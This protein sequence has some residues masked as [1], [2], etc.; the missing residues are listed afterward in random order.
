MIIV[1]MIIFIIIAIFIFTILLITF[2]IS[3]DYITLSNRCQE[4]TVY[5]V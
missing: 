5:V 3:A 4:L 1:T 2:N